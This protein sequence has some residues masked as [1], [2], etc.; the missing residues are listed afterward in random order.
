MSEKMKHLPVSVLFRLLEPLLNR[1]G[2]EFE[3]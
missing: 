3:N 2:V 1:Y